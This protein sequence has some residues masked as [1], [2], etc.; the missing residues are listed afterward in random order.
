VAWLR[1]FRWP[2]PRDDRL[3]AG[4]Y[5]DL[6]VDPDRTG[7]P[8]ALLI[9]GP[10]GVGKT[11]VAGAVGDLLAGAGVPHAVVDLDELRRGWPSPADDPFNLAVELRNLRHVARTYLDAGAHRLVLAGVVEDRADRDRY[12]EAVGV[13]LAVC[14]LRA[15]QATVDRRLARRH[16]DEPDDSS[17]NWHLRRARE[18]DRVFDLAGVED[19]TVPADDPVTAVAEAV[20]RAAGWR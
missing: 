5:D 10:V 8:G 4:A 18:L 7:A 14:R 19:F 6:V 11:S 15:D 2:G 17:L 16:A 3:R 9:T 13:D 20:V 12:A 1:W